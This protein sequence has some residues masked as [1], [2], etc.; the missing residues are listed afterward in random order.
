[1]RVYRSSESV[2]RECVIRVCITS[3]QGRKAGIMQTML[4]SRMTDY[5][6]GP[7]EFE[8]TCPTGQEGEV[9]LQKIKSLL[10]KIRARVFQEDFLW[11]VSIEDTCEVIYEAYPKSVSDD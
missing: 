4:V 11:Y 10:P 9:L 1:M 3:Q 5:P 2:L 8:F 7:D 6:V